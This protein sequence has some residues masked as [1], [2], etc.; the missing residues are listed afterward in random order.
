M[1]EPYVSV[2]LK[3]AVE[4]FEKELGADQ[5]FKDVLNDAKKVIE[6]LEGIAPSL[7]SPGHRAALAGATDAPKET[8]AAKADAK[9]APAEADAPKNFD[10][11][12]AAAVERLSA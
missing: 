8:P 1:P 10:E 6:R 7:T 5:R 3:A 11:A 4:A 2:Q 9:P 12:R